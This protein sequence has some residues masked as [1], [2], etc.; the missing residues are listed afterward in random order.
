MLKKK[1]FH[2]F[3]N[4][5]RKNNKGD[6][7]DLILP[8]KESQRLI[9]LFTA[10]YDLQDSTEYCKLYLESKS[11]I[12][13]S[14]LFTSFIITYSRC[15]TNTKIQGGKLEAK[16]LLSSF[17]NH[18]LLLKLHENIITIRNNFIAHRDHNNF[19]NYFPYLSVNNDLTECKIVVYSDNSKFQSNVWIRSY[20][21]LMDKLLKK[22]N[23]LIN[24]NSQ[25]LFD[26]IIDDDTLN[27]KLKPINIPKSK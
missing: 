13:K 5:I 3:I 25:K 20:I 26:R 21:V 16:S 8:Y 9:L 18:A 2:S 17:D 1:V 27:K 4:D 22:I 15:F 12:L 7:Y 19:E 24:E 10:K 11:Q 14:S 23:E 6:S